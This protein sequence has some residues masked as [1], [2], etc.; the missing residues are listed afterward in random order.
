MKPKNNVNNMVDCLQVVKIYC[1][2]KEI[3]LYVTASYVVFL[4]LSREIISL[5]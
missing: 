2:M 4:L 1:F 5:Y 3:K